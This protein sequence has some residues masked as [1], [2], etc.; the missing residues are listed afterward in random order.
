MTRQISS[1]TGLIICIA[2][3]TGCATTSPEGLGLGKLPPELEGCPPG[4]IESCKVQQAGKLSPT[5]P[6]DAICRCVD[7]NNISSGNLDIHDF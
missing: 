5:N 1:L 7:R 2:L 4:M 3:A 6:E